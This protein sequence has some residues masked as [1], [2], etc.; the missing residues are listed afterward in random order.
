MHSSV[1]H[2]LDKFASLSSACAMQE[3]EWVKTWQVHQTN[4]RWYFVVRNGPR[5][6]DLFHRYEDPKRV[7][8]ALEARRLRQQGAS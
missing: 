4:D 6:T 1:K 8:K 3:V 2:R 5:P 7:G